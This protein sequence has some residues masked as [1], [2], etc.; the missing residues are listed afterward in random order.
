[1]SYD[2]VENSVD[3]SEPIELFE[4]SVYGFVRRYTSADRDIMFESNLYVHHEG[5]GRGPIEDTGRVDESF[6]EIDA[7]EDFEISALFDPYP[8]EDPVNL[9]I[10]RLQIAE[11]E[12]KAVWYGRVAS[13][14]WPRIGVSQLRCEHYLSAFNR[15]GLKRKVQKSCPHLLYGPE[16]RA[17]P[18][19][20][21]QIITVS[22]INGRQIV[23]AGLT[24]L[25]DGWGNGGVLL[26]EYPTGKVNKRGMWNHV[27]DH[28]DL[29]YPVQGLT[30]GT[31][32][33]VIRGCD[34]VYSV[35]GTGESATESGDCKTVHNNTAN[36]G[37]FQ[38]FIGKNI[39]D[40][41]EPIL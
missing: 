33:T 27:G 28:L 6:I 13:V 10:K 16:C 18:A 7:R 38:N 40:S 29:T 8:T 37:G 30:P 39:Y 31:A 25:G 34:H 36:Y 4:F 26:W 32:V 20:H 19:P 11:S 24:P 17:N 5:L 12:A 23:S 14:S 9:V 35:D 3:S 22:A 2:T 15:P 1:M 41:A 21:T